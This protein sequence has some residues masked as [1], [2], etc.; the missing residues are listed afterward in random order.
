MNPEPELVAIVAMTEARVIG[1]DGG[2]PW[3][4]PADLA[5]FRRHSVGKPNI[6]GRKVWDS[7]GGR[8]LP[9]RSNIVLTRQTD[10]RAPGARVAHSPEE[11]LALAREELA[12]GGLGGGHEIAI[13]GGEEVYRLYLDR[14]TRVELT[15]IHAQLDG[16][17]FFPE[18]PGEWEVV[19]ERVRPRDERN[20]YDLTFRTL[21][22]Q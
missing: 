1:R 4:L 12:H 20:A 16:D 19:Q 18:L 2:M 22:R 10:F 21:M 5:H 17:T 3:H 13:L 14:L 9:N 15:L 8:A 6:M 11:A 7:L